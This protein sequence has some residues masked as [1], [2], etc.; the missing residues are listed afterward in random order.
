MKI[1][2]IEKHGHLRNWNGQVAMFFEMQ[3]FLYFSL[4]IIL[5]GENVFFEKSQSWKK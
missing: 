4:F 5:N 3:I 2:K 1:S